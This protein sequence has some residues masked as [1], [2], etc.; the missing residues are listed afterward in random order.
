MCFYRRM[1]ALVCLGLKISEVTLRLW[2]QSWIGN[3]E[4]TVL[5]SEHPNSGL[6]QSGRG[7]HAQENLPRHKITIDSQE[8]SQ[9]LSMRG[10]L[11][12]ACTKHESGIWLWGPET[13][14]LNP[15]CRGI[16]W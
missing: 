4:G 8:H 9:Y 6:E 5:V 11:T 13:Q 1:R 15:V 10:L 2:A 16:P 14:T 3:S 12:G 7:K